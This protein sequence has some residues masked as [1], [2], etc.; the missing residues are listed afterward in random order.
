M[1]VE[2]HANVVEKR[3]YVK[4]HN[5]VEKRYETETFQTTRAAGDRALPGSAEA[6]G[7]T[8]RVVNNVNERELRGQK[9]RPARGHVSD[10]REPAGLSQHAQ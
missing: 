7:E 2:D 9:I 8:E 3:E 4:V 10:A 5:P 1:Q 6:L